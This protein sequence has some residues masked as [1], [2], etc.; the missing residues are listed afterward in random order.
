MN[1][2]GLDGN[3]VDDASMIHINPQISRVGQDIDFETWIEE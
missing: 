1:W 2:G 3:D